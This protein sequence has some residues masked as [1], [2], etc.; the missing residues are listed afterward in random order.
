MSKQVKMEMKGMKVMRDG[1]WPREI[2]WTMRTMRSLLQMRNLRAM[3][4][5][6][7]RT[8]ADFVNLRGP[9]G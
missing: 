9:L 2:R 6:S 4:K 3:M 1:T 5:R 7:I 8:S